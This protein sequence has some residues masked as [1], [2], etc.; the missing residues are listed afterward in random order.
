[1]QCVTDSATIRLSVS[2]CTAS[3]INTLCHFDSLTF[4]K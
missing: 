3:G 4:E 1:V 2:Q